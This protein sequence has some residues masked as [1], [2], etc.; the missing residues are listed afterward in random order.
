MAVPA[1]SVFFRAT[2][3][4]ARVFPFSSSTSC[5]SKF[6][7]ER[8]TTKRGSF[9]VPRILARTRLCLRC[10]WVFRSCIV[11]VLFRS[12]SAHGCRSP[13][14]KLPADL[15]SHVLHSLSFV[16]FISP[17]L[18]DVA[19]KLPHNFFVDAGNGNDVFLHLNQK[20]L[21]NL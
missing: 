10:R 5:A 11:F 1:F 4:K 12:S 2:S 3:T 21:G 8:N 9:A 7:F 15:F 18:P 14:S 6:L 20:S 13:L 17:R 16:W 19:R